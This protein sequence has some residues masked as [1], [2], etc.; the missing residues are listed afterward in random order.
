MR[1][2]HLRRVEPFRHP[3]QPSRAD[4]RTARDARADVARGQG[5]HARDPARRPRVRRRGSAAKRPGH[6]RG[7]GRQGRGRSLRHG[8]AHG[9]RRPAGGALAQEIHASPARPDTAHAGR[10]RRGLRSA[11]TPRISAPATRRSW[12]RPNP[13]SRGVDHGRPRTAGRRQGHRTRAHHGRSD[14]RPDARRHGRGRDQDRKGARRRR[15]A[16]HGA[17]DDGRRV[18]RVHDP[19][20]QQARRL[21]SI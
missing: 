6:A 3:H 2:A 21:D 9:R 10:T 5:G 16:P 11:T 18:G 12:P 13:D 17:A 7:A 14:L 4:P 8:A 15:H 1:P 20:P 19:Q